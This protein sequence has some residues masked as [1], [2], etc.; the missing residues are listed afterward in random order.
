MSQSYAPRDWTLWNERGNIALTFTSFID[1][2]VRDNGQALSYPIEQGSFANYNKVDSPLEIRATL[3]F[4]GTETEF[5][6]AINLLKEYKQ[7]ESILDVVTPSIVYENMTLESFSYARKHDSGA[8]M[9]VIEMSLVEVRQ[10]RTQ[11]VT[12]ISRPRNPTSTKKEETGQKQPRA[13]L[14]GLKK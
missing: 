7:K 14:A 11:V 5:E 6:Y 10:V 13:I 2:D 12:V 9:L 1:I 3:G 4:Q 8:R